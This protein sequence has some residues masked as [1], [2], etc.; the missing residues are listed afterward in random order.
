MVQHTKILERKV[1]LR[2]KP[3]RYEC[4]ACGDH[5]TTTEKYN[6]CSK[7]AKITTAFEEYLMRYLINST[8][9][10]V[11]RKESV[12]YKTIVRAV[13]RQVNSTVDWSQYTDLNTIGIDEISNKKGHH[14]YLAIVS[15]KSKSGVLSV[16]AVLEDRTK[17][18]V[19]QF[20]DSIPKALK[21]TVRSVCTDMWDGYVYAAM[22]VFGKQVV[23]IDRFHIAK[24]YRAPLDTLR[25]KEM[26][27]LKTELSSEEYARLK[28]MM[29]ILRKKHE[30][31]SEVDKVSL[32]FLYQ[33]SP[34]LKIAHSY[35]LKLTNIFNT[36]MKRKSAMGKIERWIAAVEKSD[37]TIFKTFISTLVKYKGKIANY[38]K[39]RKNSGFVEGLNNKIKV[40][41]R[42]CYGV[43]S[44]KSYFQRLWLDLNGYHKYG[45]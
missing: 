3:V 22:E 41:K 38:F 37:V 10:D 8:V 39:G 35:A 33:H 19:K 25:I 40:I 45:F 34:E 43:S 7:N 17:V 36:H 44:V 4:K 15:T 14:D 1:Y 5:P 9:E 24:Q 12:S 29:W 32:E 23:V 26:K 16:I 27:R 20:L 11:S 18:S 31:L 6:R 21:Q 42:R 30:C 13:S 28:N 2:I